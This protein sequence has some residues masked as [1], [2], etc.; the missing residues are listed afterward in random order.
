MAGE[1][2]SATAGE[3][4]DAECHPSYEGDCLDPDASDYDCDGGE[5]NGPK[6]AGPVTVVGYDEFGLDRD[7]DGFACEWS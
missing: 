7:G 5:G 2:A 1:P 6:Y 4:G 3:A